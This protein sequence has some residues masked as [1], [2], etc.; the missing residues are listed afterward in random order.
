VRLYAK[1]TDS[2]YDRRKLPNGFTRSFAKEWDRACRYAVRVLAKRGRV[3]HEQRNSTE[4][5]SL[6]N[7]Y[8]DGHRAGR[9]HRSGKG[10]A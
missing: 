7:G 4:Y 8:L 2:S 10:E 6:R 1:R 5:M 9:R 3:W